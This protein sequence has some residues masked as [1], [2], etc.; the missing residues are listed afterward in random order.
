MGR[1]EKEIE[2]DLGEGLKRLWSQKRQILIGALSF[3]L[4]GIIIA[5]VSPTEYRVKTTMIP[6]Q[7]N[8]GI[9]NS[10][11]GLASLAGVDVTSSKGNELSISLYP[12]IIKSLPFVLELS[13]LP[14][15]CQGCTDSLK[16]SEYYEIYTASLLFSKIKKYT[17]RLP[18]TILETFKSE[19]STIEKKPQQDALLIVS[20]RKMKVLEALRKRINVDIDES[21]NII[22]L[23]VEMP[24]ARITAQV[25]DEAQKLLQR[26]AIE[27]RIKQTRQQ[28]EYAEERYKEKKAEFE[29]KQTALARFL[30][31]NR[32][33]ESAVARNVLNQLQSEYDISLA[34]Y[35][36]L[37][38]NLEKVKL[39]V[40]S[41]TPVYSTLQ[42]VLIPLDRSEPKRAI[43][44]FI[45][46][47]VGLV[48]MTFYVLISPKL[49]EVW[50]AVIQ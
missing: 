20:R 2:I 44:V 39:A 33:I 7:E 29:E 12:Q 46:T 26:I 15:K 21:T 1:E 43:I 11:G 42:P 18:W 47:L 16:L 19:S 10:L 50:R 49:K 27:Y 5:L 6:Q 25:A 28:L 48:L 38:R 45:T 31:S 30:D 22:A 32:S 14:I 37:A 13:E 34:I 8:S 40:K 4:V 3:T 24:E 17:L 41:E 36:D 9:G 35:T 23:T